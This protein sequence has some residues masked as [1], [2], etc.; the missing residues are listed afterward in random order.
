MSKIFQSEA[1]AKLNEHLNPIHFRNDLFFK[2]GK[3]LYTKGDVSENFTTDKKFVIKI[4]R[5]KLPYF[6]KPNIEYVADLTKNNLFTKWTKKIIRKASKEGYVI[7]ENIDMND[8][9]ALYIKNF[10]DHPDSYWKNL[11]ELSSNM[12]IYKN[13]ELVGIVVYMN[14]DDESYMILHCIS[15]EKIGKGNYFLLSTLLDILRERGIKSFSC[16]DA[17]REGLANFKRRFFDEVPC[18][19]YTNDWR[20]KLKWTL[21]KK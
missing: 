14:Q 7:K 1:W 20:R 18:Y 21:K 15:K 6:S 12:C 16:G 10:K 17:E 2:I 5:T 9:R 4:C 3:T 11:T 8:I 13:K 19:D